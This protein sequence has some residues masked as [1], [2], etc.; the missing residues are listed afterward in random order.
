MIE[1]EFVKSGMEGLDA[2]VRGLPKGGLIVVSGTPGTGKTAFATS[3][4]YYG[5]IRC[6]EP[7]VYASLIEDEDRFYTYMK[8]LGYDFEKLRNENMFSYI[9]LPTM[10]EPGIATGI[11]MVM[12]TIKSLGARRLVIDSYT[13]MSQM[14]KDEGEARTFL[15]TIIS[16]MVKQLGCTTIL[17][18]EEKVTGEK[19]MYDYVDFIAD[20]VINLEMDMTEDKRIRKLT[21]V[22][23]R[24][25]E[26][27]NPKICFSLHGGFTILPPTKMPE[28][29]P[30]K[31]IKYP[32]DPA[33]YY[34]TGIPDL[35]REI[36]G[37]PD[38]T[39]VL[40]EIDPKLTPREYN[41]VLMPLAAS[42]I[43]KER[44]CL[45]L[46]TGGV[47][48]SIL[49]EIGKIYGL[50][51]E[52]YKTYVH[53][54]TESPTGEEETNVIRMVYDEQAYPRLVKLGSSLS[55]KLKKPLLAAFGID[56]LVSHLGEKTINII[57]S[58]LDEARTRPGITLWLVKPTWPWIATSLAPLAD[59]HFKITRKHGTLLLYGMKPRTPLYGIQVPEDSPIPKVIPIT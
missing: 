6:N 2:I 34:T 7:G 50:S 35:D 19:L 9:A 38:K 42:F 37:L 1:E 31:K 4:L 40:F 10:L 49:R 26:L 22:K 55:R 48:W 57:Y 27:R 43:L 12:N 44:P 33:G 13:G 54:I 18:K 17:I 36:G 51:E 23:M 58:M 28:K 24:G 56:R 20:G 32:A 25:S 47:T 45:V 30:T 52:H 53:L 8:G 46:P 39:T 11:G 15:H 29:P 21:I 5:A 41:I 59:M 3:L 16:K 14:F